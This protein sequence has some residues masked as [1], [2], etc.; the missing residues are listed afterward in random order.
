MADRCLAVALQ[1]LG[2]NLSSAVVAEDGT[3]LGHYQA[4][5]VR[6]RFLADLLAKGIKIPGNYFDPS[7]PL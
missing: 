1:A 7:H 5:G 6:P 2:L 4:T 3:V